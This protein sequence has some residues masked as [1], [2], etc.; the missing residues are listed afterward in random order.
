MTRHAAF[1]RAVNVAGHPRV[2]MTDVRTAFAAAG[3][4]EVVTYRQSGNVLFSAQEPDMPELEVKIRE[5]LHAL[6]GVEPVVLHR[7]LSDV[8]ALVER[9][10]FG[11]LEADR[12]LKLYVAFLANEPSAGPAFPFDSPKERLE[13]V[14]KDGLHVYIVSGRKDGGFYGFPNNFIEARLGVLATSRNFSTLR[15]LAAMSVPA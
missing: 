14:A 11:A 6:L 9:H 3:C 12:S 4:A 8:A 13:A 2:K 1:L 10:P 5:A 7:R 15:Q